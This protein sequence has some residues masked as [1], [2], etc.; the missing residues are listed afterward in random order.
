[1]LTI[2][3]QVFFGIA[4]LSHNVFPL[5][6]RALLLFY[7]SFDLNA[8]CVLINLN[9]WR[10]AEI[11]KALLQMKNECKIVSSLYLASVQLSVLQMTAGRIRTSQP[12]NDSYALA[13]TFAKNAWAI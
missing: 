9:I 1:M 12:S 8:L 10:E 13:F 5:L 7:I 11:H 6:W 4:N 2:L 3:A